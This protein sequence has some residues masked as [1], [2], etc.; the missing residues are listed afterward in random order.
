MPVEIKKRGL[1][2]C[3]DVT[4][5]LGPE[6]W[7]GELRNK[8]GLCAKHALQ[9]GWIDKMPEPVQEAKPVQGGKGFL[10][11]LLEAHKNGNMDAALDKLFPLHL[12]APHWSD[13]RDFPF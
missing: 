7:R 10:A 11:R 12:P 4:C 3:G 5:S 9:I 2:F 13:V 6:V 1:F 8:F